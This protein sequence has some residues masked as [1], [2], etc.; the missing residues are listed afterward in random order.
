MGESGMK[1][2]LYDALCPV[3]HTKW[4]KHHVFINWLTYTAKTFL[5]PNV[6]CVLYINNNLT[7]I[8]VLRVEGTLV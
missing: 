7:S 3:I 6:L 2:R 4:V 8:G 1:I 5:V